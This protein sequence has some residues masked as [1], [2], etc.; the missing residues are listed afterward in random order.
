MIDPMGLIR[1]LLGGR[2]ADVGAAATGGAPADT[3]VPVPVPVAKARAS[4]S[5]IAASLAPEAGEIIRHFESCLRLVGP[6]MYEAYADPAHGWGL[7]TIGWGTIA[8][9]DGAKVRR[10]DRIDQARADALLDWEM[11]G[12]AAAVARLVTAPISHDEF[13]ALVSFAYN[14]GE[15]NLARSTLLRLLNA[16]DYAGAAAEF[17]KWNQ[18]G[19]QVLAGL[20][21]RR[22]SEQ[23]LFRGQRP[24][25][26]T[27]EEFRRLQP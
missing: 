5:V 19:G 16:R 25:L 13:S 8:Y 23:R 7:P 15:G 20:T 10:G 24:Y 2:R 14:L 26:V 18:A 6:G 3:A 11:R 17:P 9:E 1:R 21:R 22:L 4:A 27:M 12:K